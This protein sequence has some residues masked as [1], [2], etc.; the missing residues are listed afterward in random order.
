MAEAEEYPL[1]LLISRWTLGFNG[2]HLLGQLSFNT[3]NCGLLR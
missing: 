2:S 1:L 3:S